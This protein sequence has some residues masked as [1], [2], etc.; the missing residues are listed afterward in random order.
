MVR[1]VDAVNGSGDTFRTLHGQLVPLGDRIV[2][3]IPVEASTAEQ[4]LWTACTGTE[5]LPL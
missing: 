5:E 3:Q 1:I 4:S 2:D